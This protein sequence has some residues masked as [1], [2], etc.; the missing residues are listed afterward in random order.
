M[1]FMRKLPARPTRDQLVAWKMQQGECGLIRQD[2]STKCP[3]RQGPVN[4]HPDHPGK[5]GFPGENGYCTCS[6]CPYFLGLELD[7]YVCTHPN[8]RAVSARALAEAIQ[9]WE[10]EQGLQR[11]E[12]APPEREEAA[13]TEPD[14][15]CQ[16]EEGQMV[17]F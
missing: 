6:G 7:S 3:K 13:N 4:P 17:L 9:R 8:A 12:P 5:V 11:Q 16:A 10:E 2:F 15:P 14:E 1:S